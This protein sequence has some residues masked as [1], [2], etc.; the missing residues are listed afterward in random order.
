MSKYW[1]VLA[2]LGACVDAFASHAFAAE[3]VRVAQLS[4]DA[5]RQLYT[6]A[7]VAACLHQFD[8]AI[9]ILEQVRSSA[10]RNCRMETDE[11]LNEY[12]SNLRILLANAQAGGAPQRCAP[13]RTG[14]TSYSCGG[15]PP[16]QLTEIEK[17]RCRSL[18]GNQ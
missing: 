3:G 1:L 15:G 10:P 13:I 8:Q 4:C 18:L 9:T 14:P 12:E 2:L 5:V 6:Q 16:T 17:D 7:H 11:Q